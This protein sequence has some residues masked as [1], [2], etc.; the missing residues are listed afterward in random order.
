MKKLLPILILLAGIAAAHAATTA[1]TASAP[2]L[3]AQMDDCF[4]MHKQLMEKPAV[5]NRYRCW[6]AH[7]YLMD[8]R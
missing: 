1:G 4:R 5:R 2:S 7:S 3:S 8:R 6:L